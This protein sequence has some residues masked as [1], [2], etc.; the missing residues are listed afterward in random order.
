MSSL[1]AL[2]NILREILTREI[3]Q[4]SEM[5]AI[6]LEMKNY[7]FTDDI[8]LYRLLWGTDYKNLL[9]PINESTKVQD[10]KLIYKNQLHFYTLVMNN[11]KV[12]LRKQFTITLK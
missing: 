2:S 3:R 10:T 7:M 8:T 6:W 11:P 9:E 4:Q 5:K 1:V 12:K